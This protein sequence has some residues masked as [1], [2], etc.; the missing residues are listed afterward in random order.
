MRKNGRRTD[1]TGKVLVQMALNFEV[2]K[3]NNH[4][5]AKFLVLARLPSEK[6]KKQRIFEKFRVVIICGFHAHIY[7]NLFI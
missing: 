2:R 1:G 3:K 6:K 5:V 7:L 4:F